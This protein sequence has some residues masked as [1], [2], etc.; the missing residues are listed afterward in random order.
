MATKITYN[1]INKSNNYFDFVIGTIVIL[2]AIIFFYSSFKSSKINTNNGY[3]ILAKFENINGIA[4]GSDVKISGVKIGSV[5]DQ[6]IDAKSYR[7]SVKLTIDDKIKLPSD[8][9][10]LPTVAVHE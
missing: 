1:M 6:Y 3:F 5:V 8:S 10:A 9:S 7:A 2:C 4:N